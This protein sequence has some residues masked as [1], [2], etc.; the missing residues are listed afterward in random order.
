[1]VEVV[2]TAAGEPG[3]D[4]QVLSERAGLPGTITLDGATVR[5]M[6]GLI[7]GARI[8]NDT[9]ITDVSLAEDETG[10]D[11]TIVIGTEARAGGP[12]RGDQAG[13]LHPPHRPTGHPG[14]GDPR[15]A[16]VPSHPGPTG[17]SARD[18]GGPGSIAA[19]LTHPVR[20]EASGPEPS[21]WTTD[22]SPWP[23][24]RS[25]GTFA[26]NGVPGFGRL[27]DSGDYGDTYNYSPPAVD[28]VVDAPDS[29]DVAV[30]ERG[31]VRATVTITSTYT[32][33]DRVDE[34]TKSRVGAPPGGR[35]DHPRGP[36]RRVG[37]PGRHP[38]RQPVAR[39]PGAGPPPPARAV[40]HVAGRVCLHRRRARPGGRG[41]G[42]GVR[43]ARPSRPAGSCRAV[44]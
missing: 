13:A 2:V 12:G 15:P 31:P 6:L 10:L 24:T 25:D 33:P 42:R 5:S 37:G 4:V 35:R 14:P 40:V 23:S 1:M 9:Y 44:A 22:W 26:V 38:L 3:P 7:Q 43:N 11:I 36:G 30:G 21:R 27:V 39:P 41:P 20:V 29:V 28:T 19:P 8:D 17:R 34:A 18:S 16:P 32:W